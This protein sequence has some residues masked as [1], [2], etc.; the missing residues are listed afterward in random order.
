MEDRG[1]GRGEFEIV[2]RLRFGGESFQF[3]FDKAGVDRVRA[4]RGVADQSGQK[5]NIGHDAAHVGFLKRVVEPVD[6]DIARRRPGDHLGQH[7][8]VVR[9]DRIALAI[10]GIDPQARRL[11][12]AMCQLRIVPTEGMKFLSG[13][14]A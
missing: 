1:N 8:I 13:F 9:R 14:S 10:S 5:R 7:G 3:A 4:H 11:A 2:R 6:G 12:P